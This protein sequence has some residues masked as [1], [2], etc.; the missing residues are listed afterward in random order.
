MRTIKDVFLSHA[1]LL[2]HNDHYNDVFIVPNKNKFERENHRKLV[3]ELK[4]RSSRGE[5]GLIIQNGAVVA[6]PSRSDNQSPTE[7]TN[8]PAQSS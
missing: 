5:S 1:H 7:R 2:W 8:H 4:E 3:V 6:R